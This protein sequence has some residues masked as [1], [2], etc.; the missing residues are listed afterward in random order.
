MPFQTVERTT[1]GH[2]RL[3]EHKQAIGSMQKCFT[4]RRKVAKDIFSGVSASIFLC[5]LLLLPIAYL[6]SIT[7]KADFRYLKSDISETTTAGAHT[8]LYPRHK[9]FELPA[10]PHW[11]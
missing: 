1:G 9:S 4:Q 7:F 11:E 2:C 10:S 3:E 5:L 8:A 6:F